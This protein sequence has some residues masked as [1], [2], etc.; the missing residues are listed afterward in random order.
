M[1]M[2]LDAKAAMKRVVW[3][4]CLSALG[5]GG[6]GSVPTTTCVSGSQW[7]GGNEGSSEMKPGGDCIA[8]HARGEGPTFA[9][10]GTVF[11]N[12]HEADDC[13]GVNG[14]TVELTGADGK[15]VTMTTN[16]A[17]NFSTRTAVAA[18]YTARLRSGALTREMATPQSSFSCNSCHTQAGTLDAPGRIQA[19]Q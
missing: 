9:V 10:A 8:C 11:K 7:T 1:T 18:P 19:P 16:N 6:L 13:G 15:V 14:I 12:A 2:A 5:C 4:L 3:A 17:G